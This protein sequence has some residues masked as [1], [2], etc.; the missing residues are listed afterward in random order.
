[1]F[2][3]IGAAV[4]SGSPLQPLPAV[5]SLHDL[6]L[7]LGQAVQVVDQAVDLPVGRRDLPLQ[8]W[9]RLEGT[10]ANPLLPLIDRAHSNP[11]GSFVLPHLQT[12]DFHFHAIALHAQL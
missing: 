8:L 1:M 12:A 4:F 9:F 6:D 5:A 7:R 3:E 11:F 2:N 10:R